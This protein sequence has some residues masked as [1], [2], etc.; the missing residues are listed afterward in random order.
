MGTE[1]WMWSEGESYC[2]EKFATREEAV[3]DAREELGDDASFNTGMCETPDLTA[4]MP[5]A[6]VI[7]EGMGDAAYDNFPEA[8]ETWAED[9]SAKADEPEAGTALTTA[10]QGVIRAWL[11]EHNL[12]PDFWSVVHIEHHGPKAEAAG[13]EQNVSS[14]PIP[15]EAEGVERPAAGEGGS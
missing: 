1:A 2:G 12:L 6:M 15:S 8:S 11:V 14:E 9:L 5:D 7:A 10:V 3:R 13:P 4:V